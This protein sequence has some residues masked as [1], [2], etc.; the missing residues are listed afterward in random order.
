MCRLSNLIFTLFLGLSF[1]V[2]G[3]AQAKKMRGK[4]AI[5]GSSTVFPITEAIAEEFRKDYPRVRVNIGVSGTGGGFKKFLASETDIND[6]SRRIKDKEVK[7]AQAKNIKYREVPVA[8]DGITVVI[9]PQ[10]TWA[11]SMTVDELKLLWDS[12]SKITKW[13]QIRK[14]WPSEEIKL[15]GPGPDS[16]T[17]DY[18]TKAIN[19]KSGRCRADFQKSEDDHVLVRGVAGDKNAL[20]FFG[21]AYFKEN[22]KIIKAV[23]IDNGKGVAIAPDETTINNGSYS[24]LSRPIFIYVN[25]DSY[26]QKE[27]VKTFTN[28]Y[29]EKAGAIVGSVGYVPLPSD[30]Y[31]KQKDELQKL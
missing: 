4:V 11:E 7:K 20:A 12:G 16:G 30:D 6:A 28:F 21:Y 19:G 8:F 29:L 10:N 31:K 18:F 15:Y 3:M 27:A 9:N 14:E 2:P 24:P 26:K 1:V 5:D 23:K 17:F 22:N 13:N 25:V